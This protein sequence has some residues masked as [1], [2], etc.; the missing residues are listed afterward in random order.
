MAVIINLNNDFNLA[1]MQKKK[2]HSLTL[3][4]REIIYGHIYIYICLDKVVIAVDTDRYR[5]P[6]IQYSQ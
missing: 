4:L 3:L 1:M 6:S 2:P 5:Y